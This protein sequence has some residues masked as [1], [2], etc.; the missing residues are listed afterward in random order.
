MYAVLQERM[1]AGIHRFAFIITVKIL[2]QKYAKISKPPKI[3]CLFK[4]NLQNT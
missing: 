3:F 1:A 2:L 4:S